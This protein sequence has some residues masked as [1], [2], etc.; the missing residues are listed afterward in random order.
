[1]KKFN[2]RPNKNHL[3]V[4]QGIREI[5]E[6]RSIAVLAVVLL[7]K[8]DEYFVL[9]AKR[10]PKAMDQCGKMNVVCGYLD[11]DESALEAAVRET[12]EECGLYIPS[13]FDRWDPNLQPWHVDS[14][15]SSNRQNVTLRYGFVIDANEHGTP[16]LCVDNNEVK[17][18]VE[19][20]RWIS[21]KNVGDHQWAFSHDKVIKQYV[22]ALHEND[23]YKNT[24]S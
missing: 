22:S 20:P 19:D 17:G 23:W 21:L 16:E 4:D 11:W 12:W 24:R 10:G 8:D 15:P 13:Y 18:E 6:S 5:W 14:N 9:A 7:K 2:N 3:I 1:M